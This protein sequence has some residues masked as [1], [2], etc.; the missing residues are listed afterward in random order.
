MDN[1]VCFQ[2]ETKITL[3]TGGIFVVLASVACSLGFFGY[4]GVST[5]MLTIEVMFLSP[6]VVLTK[7]I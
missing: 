5:T 4:L 3:A 2:V 7:S 6:C 1:N